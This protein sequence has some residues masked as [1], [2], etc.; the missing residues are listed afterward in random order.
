MVKND[1]VWEYLVIN[2]DS[3]DFNFWLGNYGGYD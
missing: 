1:Y 2:W 3:Y